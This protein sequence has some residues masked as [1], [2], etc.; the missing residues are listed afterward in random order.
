MNNFSFARFK[1]VARWDLTVNRSFYGKAALLIFIVMALPLIGS[2]LLTIIKLIATHHLYYV[3]SYVSCVG[4]FSF[5]VSLMPFVC[6]Y[7]FHNLLTKQGR[8]AELTLPAANSEKFLW[9]ALLT[10][11]GSLLVAF[12]GMVVLDLTQM[13]YVGALSGFSHVESSLLHLFKDLD[14]ECMLFILDGGGH[15]LAFSV[16]SFLSSCSFFVLGNAVK[17]KHNVILTLLVSGLISVVVLIVC[18][19][20]LAA[21]FD[22]F[23]E[24]LDLSGWACMWPLYLLH[25]LFIIVCWTGAYWFYTRAQ[26]T[27]IRN[28]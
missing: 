4:M 20:A 11:G 5:F 24:L 16:L 10:L 19:F 18:A 3:P 22:N 23:P 28:K 17:Y 26:I 1:N 8:V 13:L 12:V 15:F 27:S 7:M 25:A 6:G 2:M 14:S 21:Y 9:H